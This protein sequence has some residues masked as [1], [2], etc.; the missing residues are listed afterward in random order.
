[1]LLILLTSLVALL[2]VGCGDSEQDFVFTGTDNTPQATTGNAVFHFVQAQASPDVV[3]AGTDSLDFDFYTSSTPQDADLVLSQTV[4][5]AATVTIT[6]LPVTARFVV[7][8]ARDAGGLPLA[9]LTGALDLQ[10]GGSTDVDLSAAV[11]VSFDF[12]TVNTLSLVLGT[13]NG[14][15]GQIT[16]TG[17]FSNGESFTFPS[18][19]FAANAEFSGFDGGVVSVDDNGEVT[20]LANGNTTVTVAY[21]VNGVSRSTGA[22]VSVSG[23]IVAVAMLSV[24]PPSLTVA[25]GNTSAPLSASFTPGGSSTPQDVTGSQF[26]SY[27]LQTPVS[28]VSVDNE[29]GAVSVTVGTAD[30]ITAT[31]IATY[32]DGQGNV[33]TDEVAVTVGHL[34]VT[35]IEVTSVAGSTLRLTSGS[36][37]PIVAALTLSD[38]SHDFYDEGGSQSGRD[39]GL[40]FHSGNDLIASFDSGSLFTGNTTG[41]T[42][43]TVSSGDA[44]DSFSVEN[45]PVQSYILAIQP[46]I[47]TVA[48]N[49]TTTY[50]VVATYADNTTQTLTAIVNPEFESGDGGE[51]DQDIATIFH[52]S[53]GVLTGVTEGTGSL[54]L[55][56]DQHPALDI[57][58]SESFSTPAGVTIT[59][60]NT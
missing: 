31:V 4:E 20:G 34:T 41:N 46:G 7:V 56:D 19:S 13:Q 37:F 6:D 14:N 22:G 55:A 47:I 43:F 33:A 3:P 36:R 27:A 57:A 23:G 51:V 26:L 11:P 10:P 58:G 17:H 49:A 21:Q 29:T 59:A 2:A 42:T 53:T 39:Y 18:A 32:D 45:I 8:T 28:G 30:N 54:D 44:S 24:T 50:S 1:L 52:T 9:T 35:A 25:D 12:I 40:E 38:G 16:I 48:V 15:V 60:P 5:F